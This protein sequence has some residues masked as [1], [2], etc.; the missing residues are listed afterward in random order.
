MKK[1]ELERINIELPKDVEDEGTYWLVLLFTLYMHLDYDTQKMWDVFSE[2]VKTQN[3]FFPKSELLRKITDIADKATYFINKGEV[4]YRARYIS[5]EE[6]ANNKTIQSIIAI[7]KEETAGLDLD[8]TDIFSEPE[9]NMVIA[10]LCGD[11]ERWMRVSERLKSEINEE[12][13][14]YGFD[15]KNSD[16]PP[17]ECANE[18]RANPRG[19]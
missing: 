8:I 9:M 4:L 11:Q 19:I 12:D 2:E 18:G 13:S 10:Y 5:H 14:F 16:A 6:L 3:R 1:K 15:K 17:S 7:L